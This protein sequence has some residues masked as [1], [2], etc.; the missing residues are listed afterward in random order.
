M[1]YTR[2]IIF[3]LVLFGANVIQG[4]TGF[5]GT[6]LAMPPS[7]LLIG[8]DKAKAILN[9]LAVLSSCMIVLYSFRYVNTR[10]L[11]KIILGM[12]V[13]MVGGI[14]LYTLCPLNFLLPV[15]GGFIVLIGMKNLC[16]KPIASFSKG[17]SYAIL[18]GAGVVHGMFVSGGA[19]LVMYAAA[20]FKD[21][22]V[23]RATI[24][25]VWFILNI[26]LMGKDYMNGLYDQ[27]VIFLTLA[28]VIPLLAATYM[29]AVIHDR[30]NQ[31]LFMKLSYILLVL[32]GVL[33][34]I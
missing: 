25:S 29:G 10:E 19:L 9:I 16:F 4:I 11:M 12:L 21:K 2:E 13:G 6:L 30:I 32:S 22:N 18:I 7:M 24:A 23:F 20:T 14:Y 17:R 26:V 28:S 5:A 27:Q 3:M 33:L 15:Y 1:T 8:P 31:G 34:F